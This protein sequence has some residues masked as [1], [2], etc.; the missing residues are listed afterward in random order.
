MYWIG[1][2]NRLGFLVNVN[3][4]KVIDMIDIFSCLIE[5]LVVNLTKEFRF[6][7]QM[8]SFNRWHFC[9]HLVILK[10]RHFLMI[11]RSFFSPNFLNQT[12]SRK[13]SKSTFF[14]RIYYFGSGIWHLAD[15]LYSIGNNFARKINFYSKYFDIFLNI[16]Q[17]QIFIINTFRQHKAEI[18]RIIVMS[19]YDK[20]Y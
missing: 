1:I 5:M 3:K 2:E 12:I 16:F 6:H 10:S 18:Y 20:L 8:E 9:H 14:L 7:C 19:T 15:L 17:A 4:E 11:L 13:L